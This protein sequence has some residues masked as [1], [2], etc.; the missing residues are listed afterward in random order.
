MLFKQMSEASAKGILPVSCPPVLMK[1]LLNAALSEAE[2]KRFI[3]TVRNI[4]LTSMKTLVKQSVIPARND[5]LTTAAKC[6]AKSETI[7]SDLELQIA[8][9]WA[10]G[11]V[12]VCLVFFAADQIVVARAHS[13]GVQ[14]THSTDRRSTFSTSFAKYV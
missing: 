8:A 5:A 3:P 7:D 4:I 9:L 13:Q 6:V 2:R 10:S 12:Q 14:N 11:I 1:A